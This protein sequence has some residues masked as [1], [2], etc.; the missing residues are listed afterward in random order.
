MRRVILIVLVCFILLSLTTNGFCQATT[1]P[2]GWTGYNTALNDY[3]VQPGYPAYEPHARY[4]GDLKGTWKEMG[5]QYGQRAGDL[6]RLVFEGYYD[7]IFSSIKDAKK[8]VAD[9]KLFAEYLS[10][11]VPEAYDFIKGIAEGAAPEF[12]KCAHYYRS[13]GNDLDKVMI[14]NLYFACRR[15]TGTQYKWSAGVSQLVSPAVAA[16]PSEDDYP[17][18]TGIVVIGKLDGPT[19]DGTTIHGGTRDQVF[20]PQLYEVTYTTSPSDPKAY[21]IWTV[22]SAG[23]I[24]GQ[25]VGNNQGVIVSGFA[26]GNAKNT[27]AYGLEWNVGDWYGACF[28]KTAEEAAT[29]LTVGRPGFI[30]ATGSKIVVPAW[31]INWLISDKTDARVVEIVPGRYAIRKPGDFGEDSFLICTNHCVATWSY[32]DKNQK[33]SVSMVDYGPETGDYSGLSASGTRYWTMFWNVK[34]NFSKIDRNMVMDWY[35]GHFYI[36]KNGERHDY[37]WDKTLA[38]WVPAHLK[39]LSPCRHQSGYPDTMKGTTVDAKVGVAQD[40]AFYF[41][42]GRPCDWVGPWDLLNLKYIP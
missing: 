22:A 16:I 15:V 42:K 37:V 3:Y 4:L 26:G 9:S 36:D 27:W 19:K 17:A 40:L 38:M 1:N 13:V 29:I 30:E 8:I 12:K 31:G 24:G 28:A 7:Q 2:S 33:T 41:T 5:V 23:E 11:L 39:S 20:F 6:I 18:C 14:I 34:Y 25:M 10:K 21:R 35:K 32:D